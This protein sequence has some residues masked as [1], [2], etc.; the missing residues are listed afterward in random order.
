MHNRAPATVGEPS[1]EGPHHEQR[2]HHHHRRQPGRRP[3]PAVHHGRAT[4]RAIPD[5]L[6][7]PV[8]DT[9]TGEWKDGDPLF[10]TCGAWRLLAENIAESLE[11]GMRVIAN[12]R[13]RQRAYVS[14]DGEK[15]TLYELQV[16]D[17][18]PSLSRATAKVARV[19]R[20]G[21]GQAVAAAEASRTGGDDAP[22]F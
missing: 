2:D 14:R 11:K 13:I 10:L 5:R 7:P 4:V 16:Y 8:P 22:P 17:A 1:T 9:A 20:S 12:G 15:R 21:N 19:S 3:G 18:G 6:H